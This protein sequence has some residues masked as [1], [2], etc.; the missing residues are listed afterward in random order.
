ML[1]E[2]KRVAIDGRSDHLR[3]QSAFVS[4]I[5][6][7]LLAQFTSEWIVKPGL[8][9]IADEAKSFLIDIDDPAAHSATDLV[10]IPF[11]LENCWGPAC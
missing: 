1:I 11:S 7:L 2:S 5:V 10:P 3:L 6:V 8:Y 4:Q 9:R